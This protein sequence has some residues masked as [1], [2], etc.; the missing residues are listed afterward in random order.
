M[1]QEGT[2]GARVPTTVQLRY[3]FPNSTVLSV[4][5]TELYLCLWQRYTS[6]YISLVCGPFQ[7]QPCS[8]CTV[9]LGVHV[10]FDDVVT[11]QTKS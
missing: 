10:D 9:D 6:L 8:A 7:N 2:T 11:V 5:R 1:Q 3:R 4:T